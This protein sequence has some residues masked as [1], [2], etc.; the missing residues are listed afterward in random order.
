[1]PKKGNYRPTKNDHMTAAVVTRTLEVKGALKGYEVEEWL[2]KIKAELGKKQLVAC[3]AP[4][5]TSV[6]GDAFSEIKT[7]VSVELP[8]AT[9]IGGGSYDGAFEDCDNLTSVSLPVATTISPKA[10]KGCHS[11]PSI[12]LPTATTIGHEAFYGCSALTTVSI[13]A[14]SSIGLGVFFMCPRLSPVLVPKAAEVSAQDGC[15]CCSMGGGNGVDEKLVRGDRAEL[16]ASP[17]E[18]GSLLERAL[19]SAKAAEAGGD[20]ATPTPESIARG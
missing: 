1:M 7:L 19:L 6:E 8:L 9:T 3:V 17:P 13:P 16:E 12:S 20:D 11:L 18:A 5:V 10:F 2:G 14:V 4:Y 15:P